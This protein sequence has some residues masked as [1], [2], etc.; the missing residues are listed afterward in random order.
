MNTKKEIVIKRTITVTIV[1]TP[2][3]YDGMTI[4]EIVA[5]EQ[6]LEPEDH[7][8]QIV[9]VV[10]LVDDSRIDL[11]CTVTVQDVYVGDENS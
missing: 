2:N 7:W 5:Y 9:D 10:D 3:D 11:A 4:D 1:T 8:S 6:G